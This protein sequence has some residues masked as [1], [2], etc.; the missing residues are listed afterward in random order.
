MNLALLHE[1]QWINDQRAWLSPRQTHHVAQVLKANTGDTIRVGRPNGPIGFGVIESLGAERAEVSV[2]WHSDPPPP[3]PVS[4]ILALPRPKMLRRVLQT[5]V[6]MGVKRLVLVNAYKVDKSYWQTPHLKTTL[7]REKMLLGLEQARDTRMPELLLRDRFRPFVED[8][9]DDFAGNSLRLLAH[10][11]AHPPLPNGIE[12]PV[13]LAIGPEG[14][15]TDYEVDMLRA[16]GFQ[17]HSFG[18]RILRVETAVPAM[19][20]RILNISGG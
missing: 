17:C 15:W 3:N 8:E 13:T 10:P 5:S 12:Q 14:G 16:H 7:L 1:H 9:L 19:L 4:L 2:Q 18:E 20:G 11:G 6:A